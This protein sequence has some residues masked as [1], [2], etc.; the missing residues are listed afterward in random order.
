MEQSKP[1][2]HALRDLHA[3]ELGGGP[4]AGLQLAARPARGMRG[5]HQEPGKRGLETDQ[6]R[7]RRRR[8]I[9]RYHGAARTAAAARRYR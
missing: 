4:R 2:S 3:Q 6:D 8:A 5:V 7:I 1:H 9:G